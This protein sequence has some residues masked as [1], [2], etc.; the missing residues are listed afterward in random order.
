M[1][2]P[3]SEIRVVCPNPKCRFYLKEGG[4]DIMKK[5]TPLDIRDAIANS[6]K[7]TSWKRMKHH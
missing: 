6:A 2:R 4:K 5:N 3:K 7:H 1:A